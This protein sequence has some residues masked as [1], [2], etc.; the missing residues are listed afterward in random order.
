M[1]AFLVTSPVRRRA[2]LALLAAGALLALAGAGLAGSVPLPLDELPHALASL[3]RGAPDGMAATL[4][5]LRLGRASSA[6]V[7]GAA[8]ALA[9][10]M[11]QALVRNPLADPYVL[12][13]S[14][15][16]AVGALAALL[17]GAA[18][19]LV[20][21]G[22]LAGAVGI[23]LLLY[24]LA[25]RDLGGGRGSVRTGESGVLLLTGVVLASACMALVTLMLSVAPESRL[26]GMVFWMIGD[27]AGSSWRLL[28]WVVLAG[29]L[30]LA[31]RRARALNVMALHADAAVTLGINVAGLRRFLFLCSGLLTACAVTTGGS[32]GFVG[33]VVPHACRHA[34]G[35]DHRILLPAA[36]LAGGGFLVLA[37]TLARTVLA[38]Q[39]LPVGVLTSLIGVPVFLF[40]LHQLHLRAR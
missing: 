19:W 37:D 1:D 21:A 17:F 24:L 16:A 36:A 8:L 40:Q 12:G 7:T 11:M 34:F 14:A 25:R 26:R 23:S 22:A 20:D 32:I 10:V 4:L 35:P 9:G 31:L 15:G 2:T 5:D 28:P 18:L 27:L 30:L 13:V 29:A 6:F 38:P 33:L 3:L 39:Q